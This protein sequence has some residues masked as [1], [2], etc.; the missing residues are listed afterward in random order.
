MVALALAYHPHRDTVRALA[1]MASRRGT[2]SR[3][4][5]L[6]ALAHMDRDDALPSLA[7]AL[8]SD[9]ASEVEIALWALGRADTDASRRILFDA[10]MDHSGPAAHLITRALVGQA[11]PNAGSKR[12]GPYARLIDLDQL[13]LSRGV[14]DP[15]ALIAATVLEEDH[16]VTRAR[17]LQFLEQ[18]FAHFHH[19]LNK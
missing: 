2:R 15:S 12:D 17:S 9:V 10:L 3:Q 19:H 6:W 1:K 4:A 16:I 13:R 11:A 5:A 8:S 18:L 14:P 7:K